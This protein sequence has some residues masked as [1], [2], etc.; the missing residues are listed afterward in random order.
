MEAMMLAQLL[1]QMRKSAQ[2]VNPGD[3][4]PFAPSHAE[5]IFRSM[6]DQQIVENL[7]AKRPLGFGNLVERRLE[8]KSGSSGGDLVR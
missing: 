7:A 6:T 1:G 5:M 3:D 2:L 8:E 4:N